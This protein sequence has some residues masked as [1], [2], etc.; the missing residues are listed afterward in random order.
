MGN[1]KALKTVV[2]CAAATIFIAL[3]NTKAQADTA[4]AFEQGVLVYLIHYL[5]FIRLL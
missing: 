4:F 5:I 2:C 3:G 1:N